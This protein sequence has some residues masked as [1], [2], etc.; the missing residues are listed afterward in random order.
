MVRREQAQPGRCGQDPWPSGPLRQPLEALAVVAR[1]RDLQFCGRGVAAG[2][3]DRG[4]RGA[5]PARGA[6]Q[7]AAGEANRR[8]SGVAAER[9]G[10]PG[11]VGELQVVV[12]AAGRP[13]R[14]GRR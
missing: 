11:Q 12:G 9:A 5:A 3:P 1:I 13:V 14:L 8:D 10:M 6:A 4:G 2:E 7:M